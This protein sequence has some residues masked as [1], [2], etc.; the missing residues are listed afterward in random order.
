[1][2]DRSALEFEGALLRTIDFGA[3]QIGRQQIR[4]EL[5]AMEI[6]FDARGEFLD[7]RR[8]G[9]AGRTFDEQMAVGEQ[10]DQQAIDE[11]FLA[12]DAFGQFAAQRL[13][14]GGDRTA[15]G[16]IGHIHGILF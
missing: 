8:L 16:N 11:Q 13:E 1:M 5:D 3:G 4:R 12:D 6:A 15:A 7:R 2:E 10:R 9:E 14:C